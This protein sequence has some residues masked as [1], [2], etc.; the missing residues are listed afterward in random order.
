MW[1]DDA[2]REPTCAFSGVGEG[3]GA[4]CDDASLPA[5]KMMSGLC[6]KGDARQQEREEREERAPLRGYP[7]A[8]PIFLQ[9]YPGTQEDHEVKS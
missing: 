3:K 2:S 4:S 6:A 9:Y 5:Q 1:F 8:S 7:I